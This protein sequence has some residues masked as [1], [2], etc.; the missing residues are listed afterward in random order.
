MI[1]SE[2]RFPP[3]DQVRGQDFS[4]SCFRR[5]ASRKEGA[6]PPVGEA[7][8]W[9]LSLLRSLSQ[10]WIGAD[11]SV[12]RDAASRVHTAAR[13]TNTRYCLSSESGAGDRNIDLI[14][15]RICSHGVIGSVRVCLSA[16]AKIGGGTVGQPDN[17]IGI[18]LEGSG[19]D[20]AEGLRTRKGLG[21]C[22]SI[23]LALHICG[24]VDIAAVLA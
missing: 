2:N 4:G 11:D 24:L 10:L 18:V 1:F 22:G 7:A 14:V 3:S 21:A 19:I 8:P 17:R 12:H 16:G 6:A 23:R 9:S 15:G 20:H 5:R 13:R